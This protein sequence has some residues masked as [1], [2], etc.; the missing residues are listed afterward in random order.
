MVRLKSIQRNII[1]RDGRWSVWSLSEGIWLDEKRIWSVWRCV[2]LVCPA[3]DY[4]IGQDGIWSYLLETLLIG[5]SDGSVFWKRSWLPD[6]IDLTLSVFFWLLFTS[7]CTISYS[8]SLL[9][10]NNHANAS[11]FCDEYDVLIFRWRAKQTKQPSPLLLTLPMVE[12]KNCA[13]CQ[14][15]GSV[16]LYV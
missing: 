4:L 10:R 7:R 5:W 9:T 3:R 16:N 14:W 1:G 11:S 15:C 13:L 6:P 12:F 8:H 2:L